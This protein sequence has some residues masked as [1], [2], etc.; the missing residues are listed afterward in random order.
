MSRR[1]TIFLIV[2]IL[3]FGLTSVLAQ[4]QDE[5]FSSERIKDFEVNITIDEDS[6]ILVQE[7]ILYDFGE[8][9]RHGIYRNIPL[10]KM[11]IKVLKVADELNHSYQ[12]TTK[13]EDGYLKIKI[14]D[15]NKV[16]KGEHNYN[17]F[18]SVV[19][20]IGYFKEH[21]ELYWNITGNEWEVPIEK[22]GA[23][24]YLPEKI[25]EEDLKLDCFTGPLYSR[26]KDCTFGLDESGDIY[27]QSERGFNP[28]E[29]LT[30]VLGWPR[31]IVQEPNFFQKFIWWLRDFWPIFIPIF[32]FIFL[33]EE[34][35]QKGKD[36]KVKKTIIAQY[37]PPDN[38]KPAEVSL[39]IK[40]RVQP[41]DISATLVD[42]AVRGYLKIKEIKK[43][44]IFTKDDYEIIKLKDFRGFENDLKDYERELLK[45]V[46]GL[47]ERV[48]LSSLKNKFYTLLDFIIRK[49]YPGISK[50]KY[51]VSDPQK[52]TK[53][54]A[55]IGTTIIFFSVLPFIFIA[56]LG[57]I[58]FVSLLASGILFLI[59]SPFMP[60]RTE[61]GTQAYWHS[62][63]LKEYINTAEKYRVQF[64][65]KESIF[66][67]YLP[68]AMIF[69][70]AEKWAKA[71]EGIYTKPPTWYE[72]DFGPRFTAYTF[73]TSLSRSM[74]QVNSV[75]VSR[76]GG[77]GSS[78]G[79]GGGGF[80]GGGGGGGGGG[81]W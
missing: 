28:G 11:R 35:W 4:D 31:G 72:G 65:E 42:L 20:A 71:F 25:S 24:I 75:F 19:G 46:F 40:Q 14:G 39:I 8:N 53:K 63:G 62:L 21:D 37:E 2:G 34:W 52:I 68:Y 32:V 47:E 13:Q 30:I 45:S 69:G 22:S 64:Q 50:S 55:V 44:G 38:L 6:S 12:F 74:S 3:F 66:E 23:K 51:F 76:P 81:S 61:K 77:S 5:L 56:S 80:S 26:E 60:K 17:I 10:E 49:V 9:F 27:F 78:S 58:F 36:P 79:F 16:I 15:P 48:R 41:K 43:T 1:S 54:W 7:N 59:F 70:L 29:G 18:Y 67:K 33:F 73:V 57:F